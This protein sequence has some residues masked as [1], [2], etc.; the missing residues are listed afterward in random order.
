MMDHLQRQLSDIERVAIKKEDLK[1]ATSEDPFIGAAVDLMIEVGSYTCVAAHIYPN[2]KANWDRNQAIVGGHLVRLFKLI[3]ALLDQ[4]CKHRRETTMIFCRLAFEAIVNLAFLCRHG[5]DEVFDSYVQY[6]MRHEKKLLDKIQANILQR[7]GVALPIEERMIKSI[8]NKAAESGIDIAS[9]RTS[10]PKN[11]GGKN[12][13][14][15]ASA[16]NLDEAYLAA[17]G[18]GSHSIHGNWMDLLEYHLE[19]EDGGFHPDCE[20]TKPRPQMLLALAK[21]TVE[22]LYTYFD[23]LGHIEARRLMDDCLADAW[24]RIREVDELHEQY[25]QRR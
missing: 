25:L 6:S 10:T 3:D 9:V 22:T 15:K 17:F 16:V 2:G 5:T 20:W 18:G 23:Y 1:S 12:V 19:F 8:Q 11:W 24:G 14:E 13:F 4:T 7:G 21:L